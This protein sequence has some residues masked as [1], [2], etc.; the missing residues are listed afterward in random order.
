MYS[1][2]KPTG[3]ASGPGRKGA[4][5]FGNPRAG[6]KPG[7]RPLV[8]FTKRR[9]TSKAGF[10]GFKNRSQEQPRRTSLRL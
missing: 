4:Y 3:V 7:D 2:L 9:G 10:L 8:R 5:L 6:G 1:T